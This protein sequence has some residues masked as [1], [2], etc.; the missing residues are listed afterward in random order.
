VDRAYAAGPARPSRQ[1]G[2]VDGHPVPTPSLVA[3]LLTAAESGVTPEALAGRDARLDE[4]QKVLRTVV[5]RAAGG[6]PH[7]FKDAWLRQLAVVCGLGSAE[8]DLLYR[9]RD[10]EGY[11]VD[12]EGLR[13]A[14]AKT[15]R[16]RPD[17]GHRLAAAAPAARPAAA[18]QAAE[19]QVVVGEI[20]RE[21]PG[22]VP[23]E[24]L[25]RLAGAAGRGGV[26][27]VCA[28][29]GLRGVGK[30]QLA[31][32]YARARVRDGW[33]LVG[34]VNAESADALLAGLARVAGRLGV[35]DPEGDSL[36]SARRLR[37]H[38][39]ARTDAGLLVFDNAAGAD[40]LRPFLPATGG[41]QVV[42]TST[43]Q[44]FA[45]LGEPVDVA[46]F[47]RAESLAY[48][49]ARTGL[50]DPAGAA[51]VAEELGDWP[52][53]L[54]QAAAT[55]RRQ[56]LTYPRYLER[57]RA[58]PA[59]AVLGS[60]PGGDYPYPAA[61]ALLLSIE[62]TEASD[63]SGLAGR[64]LRVV[65]ALSADGASRGLLGGLAGPGGD[66]EVDAAVERCAAGSLLAWSVTGD[67]VIMHRLLGRVLRERDQA[68]GGWDGTVTAA[69]DLLEPALFPEE[70]A[71]DRREE[72][73]HLAAHVEALW[74]ADA[75]GAAADPARSL[76]QLR[77]RC[78][79]VRQL[80]AAADINR[81]VD[82]GTRVLA[83]CERV[84]GADHP[85]TLTA[86]GNLAAAYETAELLE[87]AIPLYERTLADRR[88]VLGAGH[89][90]TLAA[91]QRLANDYRD[92]GRPEE[93]IPL[94]EKTVADCERELGADHRDTL[95]ARN[96]LA[97]TFEMLGR[98][99]QAIALHVKTLAD[100]ERV[101]GP[102]HPF[103]FSARNNL[104]HAY[105]T[106]GRLEQAIPLFER[107][108]ADRERVLGA[109]PLTFLSRNN[110]AFAYRL[111]GR[112]EQAIPLFERNL[113]DR[114]RILGA[115]HPDTLIAR[116]N[117]ASTYAWAGRVEE[118]IPLTQRTLAD[119]ERVLG[120]DHVHTLQS[121]NDLA[122]AYA[123]AGRLDEAIP[124]QE[125]ALADRERVLG[126]SHLDTL[127]SRY[128]LARAYA[129]AGRLEEA[130]G[131]FERT[132]AD[133]EPVLGADHPNVAAARADLEEARIKA[134]GTQPP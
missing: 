83:D 134:S 21:P 25:G 56:H 119:R 81:A 126:V 111:A 37:E 9:C 72:G 100:G 3:W 57:L 61:A 115:D 99:D 29:T 124:L 96:N 7:L 93:A 130:I 43:D 91:Q 118:A 6:E 68:R 104:A 120:A 10:D 28:V 19:G 33:G 5:S 84:L 27:V 76:R 110:L 8:L 103:T 114:E 30:T 13:R 122:V 48:L 67:A 18:D 52:L 66:A 74:E 73:A 54:A 78:W 40:Q 127:S 82:L 53:G 94:Q 16:S 123:L 49:Q 11:P 35:A 17:V 4:R 63:P 38:L 14:I 71:W 106:S 26:A 46:V 105:Q 62:A 86:R 89:P 121:R 58:V 60:V 116:G 113:A 64:V 41:T 2:T 65:A 59:A 20:P 1:Y 87:R 36:E 80:Q 109:A 47:S 102:D 44:G 75:A 95:D 92:A 85:G 12:P 45:E 42:V 133:L 98:M 34:W 15:L 77:A 79:A 69:L 125:R 70:Q 88:R 132:L 108:L 51:A 107:N 117:L 112:M 22:F 97:I 24:V 131:L 129:A 128:R 55:I 101:L 90:D 31:A 23:R 50:D 32:A 39:Q